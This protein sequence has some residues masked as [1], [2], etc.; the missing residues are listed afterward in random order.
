MRVPTVILRF[1]LVKDMVFGYISYSHQNVIWNYKVEIALFRK[2]CTN[3]HLLSAKAH[4]RH[5]RGFK[6]PIILYWS[7]VQF[8]LIN[9]MTTCT[10]TISMK[11]QEGHN[12]TSEQAPPIR[13]QESGVN[14]QGTETISFPTST[15]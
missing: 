6:R 2:P 5:E 3:F 14:N 1:L 7:S 13:G 11:K 12:H 8:S 9:L 4:R 15:I 10:A